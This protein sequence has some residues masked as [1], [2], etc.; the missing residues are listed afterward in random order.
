MSRLDLDYMQSEI[1]ALRQHNDELREQLGEWR[2]C[3]ELL[4]E[5]AES[6]VWEHAYYLHPTGEVEFIAD[7]FEQRA[8]A[9]REFRRLKETSK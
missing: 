5:L 4:A 8:R 3:A 6:K 1:D 2:E 7:Y 9:M